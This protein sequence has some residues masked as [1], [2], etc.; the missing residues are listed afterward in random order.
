MKK[1]WITIL[2][3]CLIFNWLISQHCI[4]TGNVFE[5]NTNEPL[6]FATI[7]AED[8]LKKTYQTNTDSEGKYMLELPAKR[9]Y[10]VKC[11]YLGYKAVEKKL[12]ILNSQATKTLDFKLEVEEINLDDLKFS[13]ICGR[14]IDLDSIQFSTEKVKTKKFT[15]SKLKK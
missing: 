14:L 15:V 1:I 5:E 13:I 4:I 7:T 11:S 12:I 2:F 8:N 3:T 10:T 9:K 6:D